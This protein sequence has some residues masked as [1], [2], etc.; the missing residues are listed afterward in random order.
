MDELLLNLATL[1]LG[2]SVAVIL[3]TLAGK[4]VRYG[5]RWRCLGWLLLCLRLAVPMPQTSQTETHAPIQINVPA[6]QVAVHRPA[7][8][9]T[10]SNESTSSRSA[11]ASAPPIPTQPEERNSVDLSLMP[12]IIWL[13]GVLAVLGWN[14]LAHLRFLR[15]LRRWGTTVMDEGTIAMYNRLGNEFGLNHRPRLVVCSEL[16]TPMLVGIFRSVILL[17][18]DAPAGEELRLSLLH[19]LTH[20]RRRDVWRKALAL[21]VNALYWFNPFVWYMVRRID[22]ETELA[23]DED[24]LRRLSDRDYATYGKTVLS[25]MT[26]TQRKERESI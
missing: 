18:Q 3:L 10:S 9:N 25:A 8:P 2:G 4:I 1:T 13:A 22:Q 17:P 14:L 23:C 5:A 11:V 24:V 16:K 20:Y 6:P 21:W 7:A 19:E 26:R 12:A 15:W